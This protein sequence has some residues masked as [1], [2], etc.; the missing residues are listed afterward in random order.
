VFASGIGQVWV[1]N[2]GESSITRLDADTGEFVDTIQLD[3]SPRYSKFDWRSGLVYLVLDNDQVAI[4]EAR[5]GKPTAT[6]K[7]PEGSQPRSLINMP[8][9]DRLYVIT[10]NGGTGVVDIRTN[11]LLKIL[12]PTGRGAVW[13]NPH[14]KDTCGKL[15]IVNTLSNDVTVIDETTQEIVTT[16]RVGAQP[17]RNCIDSLKRT[18]WVANANDGTLSAIDIATDTVTD[19]VAVGESPK[20]M[21]RMKKKTGSEDL[22]AMTRG[23]DARPQGSIAVVDTTERRV[24]ETLPLCDRPSHWLFEGPIVYVISPTTR[25]IVMY[26]ARL[27]GIAGSTRLGRDPEQ[28]T[29]LPITFN[30][31]G[32]RM[33]LSNADDTVTVFE[34]TAARDR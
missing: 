7:F 31:T 15:Y 33:F 21:Y 30:E 14:S 34:P 1:F 32:S 9:N 18:I 17:E 12:P 8:H 10:Y 26:D 2:S 6:L 19:T 11:Q 16:L 29:S 27:P 24:R 3:G 28:D 4:V 22:W 23:S 13:G 5:S 20:W 25:E